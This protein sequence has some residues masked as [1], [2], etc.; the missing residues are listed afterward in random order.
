MEWTHLGSDRNLWSGMDGWLE[1]IQAGG[2]AEISKGYCRHK[3]G[4][5]RRPKATVKAAVISTNK[6]TQLLGL[7]EHGVSPSSSTADAQNASSGDKLVIH[8]CS[9]SPGPRLIEGGSWGSGGRGT[10]V[11]KYLQT[12]WQ[13]CALGGIRVVP[14]GVHSV[15]PRAT[16]HEAEGK[17]ALWN[18]WGA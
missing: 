5:R 15:F 17:E 11:K 14:D 2:K 10:R 12:S 8:I 16:L 6:Q 3:P 18:T 9:Q 1:G 13:A 7:T 4:P